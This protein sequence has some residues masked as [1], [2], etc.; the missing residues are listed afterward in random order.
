MKVKNETSINYNVGKIPRNNH[1]DN[2]NT[3][4]KLSYKYI[5]RLLDIILSFVGIVITMPVIFLFIILI[6][7]ETPG[8]PIYKQERIGLNGRTFNI[9]KLRSMY[10][11]AE[12]NGAQWAQKDDIRVT[13]IGKFIRKTRIDELPQ[14]INI[15]KG[16]MSLIGPRPERSIFTEKFEKE[17]PGFKKR[18]LIKPGLT[19][20]AQVNGGY[21]ITPKEKLELDLE[22]IKKQGFK[23]DLIIIFKTIIICITG[24]GAR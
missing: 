22:Y 2:F 7:L 9:Y 13:N 21:D 3:D 6:R 16:D 19:G 23:I 10:K 20:W 14:L 24:N 11:N 1:S 8:N 5:K 4:S 18:L 17:I 12:S 15:I